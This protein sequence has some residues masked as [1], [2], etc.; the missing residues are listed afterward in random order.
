MLGLPQISIEFKST[1]A[2]AVQ[3]GERGVVA[4]VIVDPNL[5]AGTVY[6]FDSPDDV[7]ET[8]SNF[9]KDQVKLAFLGGQR[10]PK[11]VLV[12]AQ[13]SS[14]TDHEKAHHKLETYKFDYLAYPSLITGQELDIVAW[15]KSMRD[16]NGRKFKAVLP[17][18]DGDH[19]GIINFTAEDIKVNG[20]T[21]TTKDYCARIA[22]LLAGTP[23]Q[24]SATYQVLPEVE[25]VKHLTRDELN[26]RINKG[27]FVLYHDG[28]KVKVGRA[29]NSLTTTTQEKG[30]DWRKIKIVDILDLIYMDV[31]QTIEDK[32][33][34]KYANSYDSK[35][36]LITA[37]NGYLRQLE[38][39]GL[40]DKGMNRVEIDLE[41]QK[42][43][44]QSIGVD[45][46]EMT[47]QQIKEANT[48]DKIFLAGYIRP[49]DAIEDVKLKFFI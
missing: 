6:T 32:Y 24:I 23:L 27:E 15:V 29:V 22:G 7:P 47:A 37:I 14:D 25:D 26:A 49:L 28:E 13:S 44:L 33:I 3:R 42:A 8:A 16:N 40:L 35:V 41:E 31:K 34:G 17:N 1:G 43:Y 30:E 36:L 5:S 21:Y 12:Y 18:V 20:Q 4:L 2:S 10:P 11:K 45:V 39:D 46:S 9:T 48:R 19:E 38:I